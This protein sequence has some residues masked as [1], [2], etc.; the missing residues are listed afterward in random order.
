VT[1]S[2]TTSTNNAIVRFNGTN[3]RTIQTSS[4]SIDDN[5]YLRNVDRIYA[6]QDI[7]GFYFLSSSG[8][9]IPGYF[10]RLGLNSK[11]SDADLT[12]YVLD[13]KGASRLNGATTIN[14][15]LIFPT[16]NILDW[17]SDTYRQRITITDDST[18]NTA[19]F[20]F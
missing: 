1:S 8:T 12:N 18:T 5:G 16:A 6:K 3:G 17:N 20:T 7:D 9:S 15:N 14:G 4:I 10:S 2:S 19:V 11:Y 13:V